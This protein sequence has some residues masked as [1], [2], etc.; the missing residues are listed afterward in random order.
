MPSPHD[1][2]VKSVHGEPKYASQALHQALAPEVLRWLDLAD[3][4][5]VDRSFVDEALSERHADLLFSMRLRGAQQERAQAFAYLLFEHQSTP[6]PLMPFRLLGYMLRIWERW[7]RENSRA[8]RLPLIFPLVLYHGQVRWTAPL[9][10]AG[11]IHLPS[12]AEQDLG[13]ALPHLGYEL[14]DLSAIPDAELRGG[15]LLV[16]THLLLKHHAEGRLAERLE[17]WMHLLIRASGEEGLRA[18]ELVARYILETD[19][20]PNNEAQLRRIASEALGKAAE[21]AVMTTA[22]RLRAEGRQEGRRE[23][24]AR[25]LLRALRLR[26]GEPTPDTLTR[27]ALA[28]L[29][30]LEGWMDRLLCSES[31]EGLTPT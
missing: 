24:A 25:L 12:G 31:V 1:R 13:L 17:E 14:L 8:R 5:R 29:E 20:R 9:D 7:L 22:D 15:A 23:E 6:D 18:L 4:E 30:T 26:Y 19:A 28:E 21:E 10:L 3:M 11:L 27:I 16:L 2:L